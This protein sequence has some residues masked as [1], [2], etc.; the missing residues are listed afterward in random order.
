[1]GDNID[2][3]RRSL[4]EHNLTERL[5]A[6]GLAEVSDPEDTRVGQVGQIFAETLGLVLRPE[7]HVVLGHAVLHA[8]RALT[9]APAVEEG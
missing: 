6:A 4:G 9:R 1:M 3:I 8:R 5:A 7:E 2:T